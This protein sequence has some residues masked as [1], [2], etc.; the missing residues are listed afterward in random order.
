MSDEVTERLDI[1]IKLQAATMIATL[2]SMKD[3]IILLGKAG[4]RPSLI[5]ELVGTTSNHVNVVLSK[6]RK[7]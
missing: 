7:D 6:N 3:K 1:L 4:L 5:A 2:E